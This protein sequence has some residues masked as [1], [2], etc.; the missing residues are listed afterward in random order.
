M[1]VV[2][3]VVSSVP[4]SYHLH[5]HTL[6]PS[7]FQFCITILPFILFNQMNFCKY[8]NNF[9][10]SQAHRIIHWTKIWFN[11]PRLAETNEL[12][13]KHTHTA[14]EWWCWWWYSKNRN[15]K[16]RI[17]SLEM[18]GTPAQ[19]HTHTQPTTYIYRLGALNWILPYFFSLFLCVSF[20]FCECALD[21]M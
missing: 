11:C 17:D 2:F 14:I 20:S 3:F 8:W 6:F 4:A 15:K 18:R 9:S 5:I 12:N 10:H 13:L 19:T 7:P 16:Y 1:V 21:C